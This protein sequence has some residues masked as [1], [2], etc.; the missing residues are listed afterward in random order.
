MKLPDFVTVYHGSRKYKPGSECPDELVDEQAIDDTKKRMS[1]L[2]AR[3]K[4]RG[5]IESMTKSK[6]LRKLMHNAVR[7]AGTKLDDGES[8]SSD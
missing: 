4:H 7:S 2:G 6:E 8:T 1:E 5:I 3:V